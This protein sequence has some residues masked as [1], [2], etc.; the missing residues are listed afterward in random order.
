MPPV[1]RE[2]F[3]L[4]RFA[5]VE[6]PH[7]EL[8]PLTWGNEHLGCFA[9]LGEQSAVCADDRKRPSA[10][11]EPDVLRVGRVHDPPALD[12]PAGEL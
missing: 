7:G 8:D 3:D 2:T 12:L 1:V 9:R 4:D 10:D 11:G 6:R 5:L